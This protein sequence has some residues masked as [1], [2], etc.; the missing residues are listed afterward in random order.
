MYK[1]LIADDE[2]IEINA[3]KI[4]VGNNFDNITVFTSDNGIEAL[5]IARREKPDIIFMDIEMPG[6][7]GLSAI[8]EIK[9]SVPEAHFIVY[10][11]YSNFDYAQKAIKVGADDYLLKP[12]KMQTLIEIIKKNIEEIEQERSRFYEFQKLEEK[13]SLVKPFIEKDVIFS[14]INGLEGHDILKQYISLYEIETE[15]AFCVIFKV[16]KINGI[17]TPIEESFKQKNKVAQKIMSILKQVCQCIAAEYI[18]GIVLAIIPLQNSTDEYNVRIWSMNLANYV[19]NKLKDIADI[20]VGIGG[21]SC[22]FE[23]IHNSYIEAYKALTE[24]SLGMSIMHYDDFKNS[25]NDDIESLTQLENQIC[26]AILIRDKNETVKLANEIFNFIVNN[27]SNITYT[28][29]KLFETCSVI[30]RYIETNTLNSILI[31]SKLN[32]ELVASI[33]NLYAL[34]KWFIDY[35]LNAIEE[36]CKISKTRNSSIV[37]DAK[38]YIDENYDKDITLEKVA[39]SVCVTPYYLSRLFKKE[40]GSTFNSYLT[41]VRIDKAKQLMRNT[42]KSIKEISFDTGFNSQPYFCTVF[43][44]VEGISP[45]EYIQ[46]LT[47]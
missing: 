7:D 8:G 35:C 30:N 42:N 22:K 12:V 21:L 45:S 23:N 44:K 26:K 17:E 5:D 28:K 33:V 43:K 11:A 32:I 38:K 47:K 31:S 9:K 29:S 6:L 34:Q 18:S 15:T 27:E 16:I 39:A 36:V 20:K 10:T 1:L 13:L 25:N 19:R 14:V 40:M 37:C 3:F 46:S 41:K 2:E 4:I 24:D